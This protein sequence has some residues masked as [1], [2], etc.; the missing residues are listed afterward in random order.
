MDARGQGIARYVL[1]PV[2]YTILN[3]VFKSKRGLDAEKAFEAI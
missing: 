2:V 3:A 1:Q